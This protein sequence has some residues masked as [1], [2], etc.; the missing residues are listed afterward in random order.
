MVHWV[1]SYKPWAAL[2]ISELEASREGIIVVVAVV[3]PAILHADVKVTTAVP[4]I[5]Q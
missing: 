5:D 4:H 1:E 2:S 3:S